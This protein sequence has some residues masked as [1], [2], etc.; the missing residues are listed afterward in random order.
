MKVD[1]VEIKKIL[2]SLAA[3]PQL[4]K[5]L[6]IGLNKDQLHYRSDEEPWAA[7]DILAHLRTCAD[8]WGKSIMAMISQDHPTL[9][10]VSPRTWMK[11]TNY[12]EQD[13]HASLEEFTR[14]R[15]ELLQALKAL[16][17]NDWS[18]GATF[19]ATTSGREQTVLSYAQR[20]VDHE[21]THCIQIEALLKEFL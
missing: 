2:A 16:P 3:T 19:T 14:Q 10:Y 8:V 15:N 4:L 9:R 12:P 5:A 11:K 20:I 17:T 7:N 1:P 6:S 13:F 18:R 21:N